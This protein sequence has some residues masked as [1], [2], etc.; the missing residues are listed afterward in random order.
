MW[1]TAN[2]YLEFIASL[3]TGCFFQSESRL[4]YTKLNR[5]QKAELAPPI[6]GK[7]PLTKTIQENG[8][9]WTNYLI[10]GH[11]FSFKMITAS[12]GN[13]FADYFVVCGLDS[14]SGLEPDQ[15]SGQ[16]HHLICQSVSDRSQLS[17]YHSH[18]LVLVVDNTLTQLQ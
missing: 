8:F 3:D 9:Y 18:I 2:L 16:H 7:G 1:K 15:L 13:R 14:S 12:P 6:L 4:T 10:Y 17:D 11:Y 5:F